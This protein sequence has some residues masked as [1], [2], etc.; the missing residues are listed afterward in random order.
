MGTRTSIR[1][2]PVINAVSMAASIT[3]SVTVLQSITGLSYSL[4]WTGT[5]P[6]GTASV[7]VSND[8]SVLPNGAVN[9]AGTW[10][11]I[12]LNVAGSPASSIAISGNTGTAFI[13]IDSLMAYAVR[14]NYTRTSGTGTLT[15][16]VNGKVQ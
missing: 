8:Y 7:D 9:N 10:T 2:F 15:A 6:I 4:S 3:S 5:S 14:L 11:T 13:D 12:E 16:Y 1:P